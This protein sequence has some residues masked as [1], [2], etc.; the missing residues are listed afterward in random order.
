[1]RVGRYGTIGE[2][3]GSVD[4]DV[5][6]S[7]SLAKGM[8]RTWFEGET[9]E[10]RELGGLVV[11]EVWANLGKDKR[12]VRSSLLLVGVVKLI[13]IFSIKY[14]VWKNMFMENSISSLVT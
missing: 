10:S 8:D 13:Q 5:G 7:R 3:V 2:G 11:G 4:G 6:C 14:F 12:W 9:R 1:M